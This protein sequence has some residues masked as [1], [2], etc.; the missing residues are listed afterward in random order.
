MSR[1]PGTLGLTPFREGQ[2]LSNLLVQ[3]RLQLREPLFDAVAASEVLQ[4]FQL[5]GVTGVRRVEAAH[6]GLAREHAIECG[7]RVFHARILTRLAGS[8][9]GGSGVRFA[10]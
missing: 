1:V 3:L 10:R 2:C 8:A 4:L 9:T 7:A 6:A 5:Q